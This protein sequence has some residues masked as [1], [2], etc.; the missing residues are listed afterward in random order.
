VKVLLG[1]SRLVDALNERV[2][3][4]VLWLVLASVLISAGNAVVRK[5]FGT[6]SNAWLEIQW[7]LYAA[8]FLM[9]AGY[10]LKYN[11]HVRI[12]VITGRFSQRTRNW[13]D[14]FGLTVFLMPWALLMVWLGWPFFMQAYVS[15]EVSSNFGGLIRWPVYIFIPLGFGLLGL[16]GI[17]ELI[18]RVAFLLDKGPDPLSKPIDKTAEEELAEFVRSQQGA[19]G[20]K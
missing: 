17:S 8:V 11:E 6:S 16:Q 20:T 19:D 14:V 9:A 3:R 18:K 5:V 1:L 13:I 2:G 7:Y 12:D 10:T 15:G 4:I